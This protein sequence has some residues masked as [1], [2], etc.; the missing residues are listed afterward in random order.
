MSYSIFNVPFAEA[1]YNLLEESVM[2]HNLNNPPESATQQIKIVELLKSFFISSKTN[3]TL[4][5]NWGG[6]A[7]VENRVTNPTRSFVDLL[8]VPQTI[9]YD[10]ISEYPLIV[11]LLGVQI[12]PWEPFQKLIDNAGSIELLIYRRRGKKRS[13]TSIKTLTRRKPTRW[14]HNNKAQFFGGKT[15]LPIVA[16]QDYY[17]FHPEFLLKQLKRVEGLGMFP[18]YIVP[19]I[20]LPKKQKLGFA[21]RCRNQIDEIIYTSPIIGELNLYRTLIEG[22]AQAIGYEL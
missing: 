3:P 15:N 9:T 5:F 2:I 1:T 17:D 14:A 13:L 21:I 10:G 12:A 7:N 20:Y 11:N 6:L 18:E 8:G 4:E 19:N 16:N 22:G